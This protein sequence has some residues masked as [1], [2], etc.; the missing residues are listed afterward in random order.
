[1]PFAITATGIQIQ[2][3]QEIVDEWNVSL[4]A[5]FGENFK[6]ANGSVAGKVV[7]IA[8]E[9]E[10][11][12]QQLV[13]TLVNVFD[14]NNATTVLLDILA[15]ITNTQRQPATFSKSSDFLAT[16]APATVINNGRQF[17]LLQTEDLWEV[18]DGPFVIPGGG[19]IAVT[20]QAVESGPKV[21]QTTGPA[22][23]SIVL[24]VAGWT[25]IE[26]TADIDPE[27]IGS[28]IENDEQLKQRR[29]DELLINGNDL[30]AIRAAVLKVD[31]VSLVRVFENTSCVAPDADGIPAGA[32]ETMVDGGSDAAIA[33]AIQ[34]R[35]P[36]GAEAFG[37]TIV[38]ITTSE[39]DI[40]PIGFT[41][42]ADIDLWIL[43]T[44]D[45]TGA[46]GDVPV[47]IEQTI[48]DDVLAAANAAFNDPG[49]DAIPQ[50]LEGVVFAAGL[51]AQG[52]NSFSSVT[53]LMSYDNGP[54]VAPAF[55]GGFPVPGAGVDPYV[56][57]PKVIAIRERADFDSTRIGVTVI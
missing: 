40:L 12:L 6:L 4:R 24:G 13:Q 25:D 1:M 41:R 51:D 23:W 2:S 16:G 39:G 52:R 30:E 38:N 57:T 31:D 22:G 11:L 29:K 44:A 20:A 26:S 28:D 27:D 14:P 10:A 36:P 47:N 3:L 9:R 43:I 54:G 37:S 45:T 32:F 21:F 46:E 55:P 53:V 7:G 15:D 17:Q 5:E 8:S 18:V 34:S 50:A 33:A 35:R 42:P 19:T 48:L 49:V 56:S